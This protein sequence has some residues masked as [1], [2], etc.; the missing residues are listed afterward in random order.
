VGAVALH[1]FA[2]VDPTRDPAP[3]PGRDADRDQRLLA[4]RYWD[5]F[6]GNPMSRLQTGGAVLADAPPDAKPGLLTVL[7]QRVRAVN[8]WALG[9]RGWE[10]AWVATTAVVYALPFALLVA[11]MAMLATCAQALGL[12][13]CA[14][15]VLALPLLADRRGRRL[16]A[17]FWLV[18]LGACLAVLALASFAAAAFMRAGDVLHSLDEYLGLLLAGSALPALAGY[19][20]LR[21]LRRLP[22]FRFPRPRLPQLAGGAR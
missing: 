17:D 8:D 9:R 3:P 4:T 20:L 5:A 13:L 10:R 21:R 22:P 2:A 1:G 6:V 19:L 12:V 16:V 15:A 18:P 11:A 14:G 7:R